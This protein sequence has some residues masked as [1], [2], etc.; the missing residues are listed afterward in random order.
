MHRQLKSLRAAILRREAAAAS[1]AGGGIGGRPPRREEGARRVYNEALRAHR[2]RMLRG[3]MTKEEEQ[4]QMAKVRAAAKRKFEERAEREAG[5]RRRVEKE[6]ED[7]DVCAMCLV[8]PVSPLAPGERDAD[9]AYTENL[10]TGVR[11]LSDPTSIA[12]VTLHVHK[13]TGEDGEEREVPHR[14][15]QACVLELVKRENPR[16]PL[17]REPI[18][19]ADLR[20]FGFESPQQPVAEYPPHDEDDL[21]GAPPIH[22]AAFG[23]DRA[24]VQRLLLE[25]ASVDEVEPIRGRTALF[26]AAQNGHNAVVEALIGWT[27]DEVVD[28]DYLDEPADIFLADLSGATP[29]YVAALYGHADVVQTLIGYAWDAYRQ[30]V[31]RLLTTAIPEDFVDLEELYG[32]GREGG[33]TPLHIAAERGHVRVVEMLLEDFA[34]RGDPEGVTLTDSDNSTPLWLAASEGHVRV[35]EM[36]LEVDVPQY[37][38]TGIEWI[39][40][41]GFTPLGIAAHRGHVAVVDRL[42]AHNPNIDVHNP[43]IDGGA[44]APLHLAAQAGRLAVVERLLRDERVDINTRR[45]FP[46]YDSYGGTPLW[47]AANSGHVDV[48]GVLLQ[49]GADHTIANHE[50]K[51]PH[52][53]ALEK[54][55]A[56]VVRVLPAA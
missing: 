54:G 25:G 13:F 22:R 45:A 49:N 12:P 39:N 18:S 21:E 20:R 23:G 9:P 26:L 11:R 51:T 2:R 30:E 24:E 41:G 6:E 31:R 44:G 34:D 56:D 3:G 52:N 32:E 38:D 33:Y 19:D 27:E 36:L 28:D 40:T 10:S 29:L 42:L 17:C 37:T 47:L 46:G 15:C 8:N 55:H 4:A 35:V 7:A 14:F 50:G 5:K 16:C 48:V 53:I 1:L 43:N